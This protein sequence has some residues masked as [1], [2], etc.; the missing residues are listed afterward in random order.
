MAEKYKKSEQVTSSALADE[1]IVRQMY[2][3]QLNAMTG[4]TEQNHWKV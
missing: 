4:E 3:D 2:N 1:L